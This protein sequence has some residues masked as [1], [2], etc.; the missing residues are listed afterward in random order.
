MDERDR[1]KTKLFQTFLENAPLISTVLRR[2][3]VSQIDIEELSQETLVRA[4]EAERRTEIDQPLGYLVGIAKNV[5]RRELDRRSKFTLELID[6]FFGETHQSD[7][8]AVDDVVDARQRMGVFWEIVGALPTQCRKVFV[9]KYVYGASH[10]EIAAKLGIAVSTVEKHVALG[11]ARCREGM[12]ERT[13]ERGEDDMKP[14]TVRL[15][16]HKRRG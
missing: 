3:F 15:D 9:L 2:Y 16:G 7:E 4:L 13:G 11:L 5:A 12:L 6:D 1:G 14:N 10:K 8:P